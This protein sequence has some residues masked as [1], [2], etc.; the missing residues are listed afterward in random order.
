MTAPRFAA[1]LSLCLAFGDVAAAD[2]VVVADGDGDLH[3]VGDEHA[4]GD[5]EEHAEGLPVQ[6]DAD[7]ALWSGIVFLLF[8]AALWFLAWKPV[9]AG[10]DKR[11][12]RIRAD[13]NAAEKNRM[14]T[15]RLMAQH[16]AEM[17]NAQEQVKE[18]L[19]EARRDADVARQNILADA[20]AAA[21]TERERATHE[22]ERAKEQALAE[23]FDTYNDRV[24]QATESVLGRGLTPEDQQRLISEAVAD[25]RGSKA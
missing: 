3:V 18:I 11:E 17:G 6:A 13:I 12:D 2:E 7:L 9:S 20:Q 15:E 19:A 1:V 22:I 24:A 10:L 16:R 23:L 21:K 14:E 25:F 5:H 8:L 4:A